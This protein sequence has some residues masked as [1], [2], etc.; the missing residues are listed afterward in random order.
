VRDPKSRSARSAALASV[1]AAA[2]SGALLLAADAA[3][4]PPELFA[5]DVVSTEDNEFGPAF[6]P[7][8]D[9]VFFCRTGPTRTQT[10]VILYSEKRGGK[11]T[12][13]KVAPFSGRYKD[14][15]PS[16]SPDG[17]RI[18]FASS[19]P[20][21][22]REASRD[23]YDLWSVDRAPGG[24]SEP[25][26]L[27][28]VNSTGAE[29]TTSIAA[30]GTLY[31]ASERPGGKGRRDL[32]AARPTEGGG[33]SEAQPIT[34]LNTEAD[35]SNEWI[36][37]DQTWMLFA[38]DRPGGFGQSDFYVTQRRNGE[39]SAPKNLGEPINDA[40]AVLTPVVAGDWLYYASFRGFADKPLDRALDYPEFRRLIHS[41]GNGLGDIY[42]IPLRALELPPSR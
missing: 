2:I 19:R 4:A 21:G 20:G 3:L 42:R 18:V 17:R 41:P 15:D 40:A 27:G 6:T 1:G 30:D 10:Q 26:H 36:A 23:D 32:Y 38:S 33:Y 31:L 11:W 12:E 39:W 9:T 29:T 16:M 22:G 24:W 14:L 7:D 37:P 28:A 34:A 5:P 13:P 8:G 35:D 25:R